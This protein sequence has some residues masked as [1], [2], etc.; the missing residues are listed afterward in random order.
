MPAFLMDQR[1]WVQLTDDQVSLARMALDDFRNHQDPTTHA[2]LLL[3]IEFKFTTTI[4]LCAIAYV[5]EHP[6][7]TTR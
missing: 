3:K 1:Q 5:K 7:V 2:V 6:V 4:A